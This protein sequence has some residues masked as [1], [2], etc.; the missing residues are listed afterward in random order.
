MST[1]TSS[2]LEKI[3]DTN[4]R[5]IEIYM[6]TQSE[7]EEI[8]RLLEFIKEDQKN[9]KLDFREHK[10]EQIEKLEAIIKSLEE[11]LIIQNTA[12]VAKNAEVLV[13]SQKIETTVRTQN[14][15]LLGAVV[16]VFL[17]IV[18]KIFGLPLPTL[19]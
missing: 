1:L 11:K 12:L 7:Y 14:K 8:I 17:G 18:A 9:N 6:E 10:K 4:T 15:I 13:N 19:P 2:Q 16:V 3:L 5:A